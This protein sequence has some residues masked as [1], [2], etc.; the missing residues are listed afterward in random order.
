[1][2]LQVLIALQTQGQEPTGVYFGMWGK[3]KI[4][5]VFRLNVSV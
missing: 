4:I 2:I 5:I 3:R 1:M